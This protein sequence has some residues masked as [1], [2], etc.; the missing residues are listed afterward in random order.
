MNALLADP[1][2]QALVDRFAAGLT[3]WVSEARAAVEAA[4]MDDL[5]RLAHQL[6]G[7]GG[8]F[9]FDQLTTPAHRVERLA[10]EGGSAASLAEA[11]DDLAL[12]CEQITVE[13]GAEVATRT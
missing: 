9:G 13:R 12:I 3:A 2:L 1:E 8:G 5:G 4:R 11:L 7:A 10:C 6:R